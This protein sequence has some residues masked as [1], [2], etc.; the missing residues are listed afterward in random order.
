[1]NIPRC[2]ANRIMASKPSEKS[3]E[4]SL[5]SGNNYINFEDIYYFIKSRVVKK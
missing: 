3:A 2:L 5:S 1:M 4:A